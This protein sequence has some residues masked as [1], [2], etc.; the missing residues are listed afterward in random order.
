MIGMLKYLLFLSS[1][2]LLTNPSNPPG[3]TSTVTVRISG[4]RNTSGNVRMGLYTSQSTFKDDIPAKRL[5]LPKST[6]QNGVLT[7]TLELPAGTFGFAM[8]DDENANNE[9]D[10]GFLLPNEGFGFSNY[11]HSGMS[12]PSFDDFKF[13]VNGQALTVNM[14]VSYM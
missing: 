10:Y 5:I 3:S 8:L 9:M 2:L 6:I 1:L 11:V 13:T 14:K 12:R 4:F 7:T